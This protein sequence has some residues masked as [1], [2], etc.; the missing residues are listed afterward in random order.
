MP[1]CFG[2]SCASVGAAVVRTARATSPSL[3]FILAFLST[4]TIAVLNILHANFAAGDPVGRPHFAQLRADLFAALDRD[5]A[6]RM[7][8]ATRRRI[9]RARHLALDRPKMAGRRDARIGH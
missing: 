3:R 8:H 1:P 5:R 2:V 6:A 9:D 4:W 7:K